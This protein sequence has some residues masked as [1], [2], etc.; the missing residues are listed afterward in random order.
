VKNK[1]FIITGA[2]GI[3]AETITLALKKGSR[4]FFIDKD[5]SSCKALIK[6]LNNTGL[7][8]DYITGDLTDPDVAIKL[9]LACYNKHNRIDGLFNVVGISGRKYGDGPAHECTEEGW[10]V[11]M[12]TNVDTQYRMCREVLKL[13]INQPKDENG[14]RG[15]ILNMA[16]ILGISPEPNFFSTIAYAA[17]KGAILS[18]TKTIA[19]YYAKMGIRANAIAPGLTLT[20]MSERAS[21]NP[22][23]VKF[24]EHQQ[25][26]TGSVLQA[27]D[28]ADTAIFLLSS[29]SKII[30]GDTLVVDAGWSIS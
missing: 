6:N 8:A 10:S 3:A 27:K 1:V 30:T 23:I 7:A 15:T 20:K 19:A 28:I 16:S 11:T 25:P 29:Q 9:V 17:S 13:M 21:V 14:L 24:M 12:K 4:V 26:L 18:M 22:E 2:S 5:E